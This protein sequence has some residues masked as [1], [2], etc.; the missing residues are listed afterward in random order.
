MA[1]QNVHCLELRLKLKAYYKHDFAGMQKSLQFSNQ[2]ALA[3]ALGVHDGTLSN[4]LQGRGD[5]RHDHLPNEHVNWLADHLLQTTQNRLNRDQA[6]DLW[7]HC[8]T[9]EFKRQIRNQPASDIMSILKR[10]KPTLQVAVGDAPNVEDL[11]IFEEP[12]AP[13]PDEDVRE[14][15]DNIR[16]EVKTTAGRSL[17]I[18]ASSP[19]SWYWMSPSDQHSGATTGSDIVPSFGGYGIGERG[20]H[21]VI[22]IE[23]ATPASPFVRERGEPMHLAPHMVQALAEELSS[24]I[25]FRWGEAR[26]F[27][28]KGSATSGA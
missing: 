24:G 26:F 4:W 23:L 27:A 10:K 17:V 13:L 28:K 15:G 21:R 9:A 22:A 14:I 16:F 2:A 3:K 8:T 12:F 25:G 6:Y 5:G 11:Q 18:L 7:R 1:K 20:P 19:A